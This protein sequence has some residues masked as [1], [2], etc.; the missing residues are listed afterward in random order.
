MD[1]Q[2]TKQYI[3]QDNSA[4]YY[5]MYEQAREVESDRFDAYVENLAYYEMKQNE[6]PA[7]QT[8]KPWVLDVTTPYAADVIN[9]RAASLFSSDYVGELQPLSPEDVED[10]NELNKLHRMFW[11]KMNMNNIIN[12]SIL[13]AMVLR[14]TYVHTILDDKEYGGTN[15]KNSGSLKAYFIDP[16][17][18]LLDPNA[19][20][21]KDADYYVIPERISKDEYRRMFGKKYELG[22]A[23]SYQPEER[24]EG[25]VGND[26]ETNQNNILT[27]LTFYI[28][29]D[30]K[31]NKIKKVI[32]VEQ[33]IMEEKDLPI[34]HVPIAQ[35]RWEKRIK[36][37]F[38]IGLMDRLLPLQKSINAIESASTTAAL[39]FASPSY[40][41]R[42]GSGV[43]PR[44]VAALAG[45]P[46]AVF[47]VDGDPSNAI[48]PISNAKVDPQLIAMRQDY[49]QEINNLGG[50][51][52]Q[53]IGNFGSAGNT[54][55]GA[56]EASNRARVIEQLFL[57]N[58]EEFIEDLSAIIVEFI[59]K[60]FEG[61]ELYARG[62]KQSDGKYKFDKFTVNERM[63]DLEYNFYI[64]M[65]V[66]TPYSKEKVKMLLQ[67]L[68]QFERQ[69]DAPVK[70][71][72]ILD[73]IKQYNIPNIEEFEERYKEL[74]VKD[75]QAKA[76]LITQWV[77]V[78]SSNGIDAN[79]I[80][81]GIVEIIQGKEMPTI[82][83]VTVMIEQQKRQQEQQEIA[84]QQGL[85]AKQ[86]Q[87]QQQ[88][89]MQQ[90]REKQQ[91]M[92]QK[93]TG[94]EQFG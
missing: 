54:K 11:N 13:Y 73:I 46:G 64:Q 50:N 92:N 6:L 48:K 88:Q 51:S 2:E 81:Q 14:E 69:Y 12:Q 29:D 40:A 76:E 52:E 91:Q 36:S 87:L 18:I 28:K 41:V 61:E 38:G 39:A 56:T 67:E 20:C 17:S 55:G 57:N 85:I 22:S 71:V 66:R 77:T 34:G 23:S 5:R 47:E 86:G 53:F 9:I 72:T 65:D 80:S 59:T 44:K 35:L 30:K 4:E 82:E 19:R 74:S 8:N 84:R 15:R 24:G 16:G 42:K 32:M 60:A 37:P 33:E 58:L 68:Y 94:D 21:F 89:M 1:A 43:D 31:Y 7:N 49:R 78:A 75:S 70:T 83:K 79:I 63:K 26:Y 3:D 25:Y 93:P 62:E 10:I 90:E 45:A 27:K